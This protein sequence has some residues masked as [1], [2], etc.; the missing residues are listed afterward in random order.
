MGVRDLSG[1]KKI[2]REMERLQRR[3]EKRG[4]ENMTRES[5]AIRKVETYIY[6]YVYVPTAR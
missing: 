6:I 2:E 1:T 3:E 5:R 4:E